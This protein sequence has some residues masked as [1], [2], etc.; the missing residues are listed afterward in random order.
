LK[1]PTSHTSTIAVI[2][3]RL[4][5][6]PYPLSNELS[7]LSQWLLL[8]TKSFTARNGG[9]YAARRLFLSPPSANQGFSTA[10]PRSSHAIL[11]QC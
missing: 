10:K 11:A 8:Q 3:F 7:A 1:L 2:L 6:Q 9:P 5:T 4:V